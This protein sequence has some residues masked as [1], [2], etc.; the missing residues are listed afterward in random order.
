[1]S[2]LFI[3]IGA[4]GGVSGAGH[5]IEFVDAQFANFAARIHHWK[6]PVGLGV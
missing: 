4:D 3:A 2:D 6:S 1:M 5:G